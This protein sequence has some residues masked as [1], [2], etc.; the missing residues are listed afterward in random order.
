MPEEKAYCSMYS[1]NAELYHHG[2]KGMKWGVRKDSY[3]EPVGG[4]IK[5]K[6]FESDKKYRARW[7]AHNK[8]IEA[9]NKEVE[10]RNKN[11]EENEMKKKMQ[12][13]DRALQEI[14]SEHTSK[15]LERDELL[16]R[17]ADE[18][19]DIEMKPENESI[20]VYGIVPGGENKKYSYE[21]DLNM[22]YKTTSDGRRYKQLMDQFDSQT[23]IK[24]NESLKKDNRY[25]TLLKRKQALKNEMKKKNVSYRDYMDD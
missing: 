7:E 19:M 17:I 14:K 23:K 3:Y 6:F 11:A 15:I 10:A 2:V 18:I 13:L 25:Q 22:W 1:R 16:S 20:F 8:A 4:P 24:R 21:D 9:H 12:D 5:R